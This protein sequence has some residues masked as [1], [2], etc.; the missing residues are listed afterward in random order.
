MSL[1]A[2]RT[3]AH[4]EIAGSIGR[5]GMGEVY[6]ARDTKLGREVAVKILPE[7]FAGDEERLARFRREAKLL[8]TLNHPNI[9]A[10]HG[11]EEVDAIHF[12]VLEL[13]EGETLAERIARGP[14]PLDE[15]IAIASKIVAALEEAHENGIVHRDLKPANV[16]LTPD[17]NVK[18]LDFGL[19]KSWVDETP[20]S[21]GSLSPTLTRDATG[22]GIILGTAAYMSPEQAKGKKVDKRTDIFA[23]GAVLFE[24]LT[25]KKAFPGADVSEVLAA[26]LRLEPDWKALPRTT[27]PFVRTLLE[28]CLRKDA[29]SRMRDMGDVRV[30]L[31][32]GPGDETL[33]PRESGK[34]LWIAAA[35]AMA[36]AA[37]FSFSFY[38]A[39]TSASP[40][41]VMRFE[42][43]RPGVLREDSGSAVAISPDGR[44]IAYVLTAADEPLALGSESAPNRRGGI[45]LRDIGKSEGEIVDGSRGAMQPF[46]S[47]DS[48]WLAFFADQKLKKVHV[49]GGLATVVCDAPGSRGGTWG[50]DGTIV[51]APGDTAGVGLKRVSADGGTPEPVTNLGNGELHR[52][53]RFLP[54]GELMYTVLSGGFHVQLRA[55]SRSG[56][57]KIVQDGASDARYLPS[58]HLLFW[59]EGDYLAAPFDSATLEVTGPAV[60]VVEDVELATLATYTVSHLDVSETGSLIYLQG[61]TD[62]YDLVSVRRSG[63]KESLVSEPDRFLQ[64]RFSPDGER[65][66]LLKPSTSIA[67]E[68]LWVYD[69]RLGAMTRF[70]V[71]PEYDITPAWSP[72]G[73][74]IVFASRRDGANF[75]L[76]RKRADGSDAVERLTDDPS[77]H[78]LGDFSPDGVHL[79]WNRFAAPDT[80]TGFDVYVLDL[81]E[82]TSVPIRNTAFEESDPSFS[83]DG[84]FV[85]FMSNESG[86]FE[87]Y[88]QP[89][90]GSGAKWQ[91]STDG[92]WFPVFGP[93]REI[94]YQA[95]TSDGETRFM[96][97]DYAV[98]GAQMRP[99]RP[100]ELFRGPYAM[101]PRTEYDVSPDG[102]RIVAL[103]RTDVGPHPVT[104]VLNWFEELERLVPTGR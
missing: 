8:A 80:N 76:Y 82:G 65:L 36:L 39:R 40:E 5:G 46:F 18:V 56:E 68:D 11:F 53:P 12:L 71:D 23:F 20:E 48:E 16:K 19:A 50:A 52:W 87:V 34:M 24:M 83:P 58:G 21:D 37:F 33:E 31:E 10:I 32:E 79:A 30:A 43:Q 29:R 96:V 55:L 72:D 90:P 93:G 15:A 4:Y 104:L 101:G 26:V 64:P 99:S 78:H 3:L 70:T 41:G 17:D 35:I 54:S 102:E 66:A 44:H 6:R 69:L 38:G 27:P 84:R 61:A 62:V 63:E 51:F 85:A 98:E 45:L 9:A 47:P 2:G 57:T 94:F 74:H 49:D 75:N 25:G 67:A 88:V 13:V 60:P 59:R 95:T 77:S 42:L 28:R 97:V 100:R 103:L 1:S 22:A 7:E 91:V 86:R 73:R 89:F 92:G 14:I 81:E